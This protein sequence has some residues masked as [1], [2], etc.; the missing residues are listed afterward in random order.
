MPQAPATP[1]AGSVETDVPCTSGLRQEDSGFRP[2]LHSFEDN[3]ANTA[4][5]S[6]ANPSQIVENIVSA[7]AS[8]AGSDSSAS[9]GN[10]QHFDDTTLSGMASDNSANPHPPR[11]FDDQGLSTYKGH[12]GPR[13][14]ELSDIVRTFGE[15]KTRG[16]DTIRDDQAGI[17]DALKV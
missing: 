4:G 5:N 12:R 13:D 11:H 8:G 9:S 1:I 14:G 15:R 7:I 6:A 17:L 3:D 10:Q 16:N 2:T